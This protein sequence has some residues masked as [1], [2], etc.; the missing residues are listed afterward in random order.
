M[1]ILADGIHGLGNTQEKSSSCLATFFHNH[2]VYHHFHFS[3]S[4][5]IATVTFWCLSK[6]F[7]I[8]HL[9]FHL[10]QMAN[11]LSSSWRFSSRLF[12]YQYSPSLLHIHYYILL[13]SLSKTT[14][15]IILN[16]GWIF[17]FEVALHYFRPENLFLS[18]SWPKRSCLT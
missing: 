10:P 16:L 3:L 2:S 14:S 9:S 8:R 18:I 15:S 1:K 12:L 7:L 5:S 11:V 17:C 6:F 4:L 13:N